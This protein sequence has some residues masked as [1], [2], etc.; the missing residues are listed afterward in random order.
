MS[1]GQR[2]FSTISIMRLPAC[3][4][5]AIRV[6]WKAAGIVPLPGSAMPSTSVK[7]FIL[8]AV[9]KPEQ[10]PQPG[11][12]L[13]SI[14]LSSFL[15]IFPASKR[16]AASKTVLTLISTPLRRPGSIGPPLTTIA[17]MFKRAA[18]INIP[19]TILSQLGISTN[20][21]KA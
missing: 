20:P 17:G 1:R 12:A 3:L 13:C 6:P 14:A 10:E 16:P 2:F 4:A 19:G 18:A 7:Q 9:N 15:S 5:R 21:S 8:L 11:Q